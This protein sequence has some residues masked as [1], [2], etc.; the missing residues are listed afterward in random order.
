MAAQGDFAV[1]HGE[2][3]GE[4]PD[5][6]EALAGGNGN[7]LHLAALLADKMTVLLKICAKA[8]RLTLDVHLPGQTAGNQ[9]FQAIVDRGQRNRRHA[10]L[11]A[12]EHLRRRRMIALVQE[13]VVNFPALGRETMAVMADHLLI[14]G[15]FRRFH[16]PNLRRR[17]SGSRIILNW[18][19][20][21]V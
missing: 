21:A 9:R 12:K 1:R 8:G 13:N 6:L 19:M 7:I 3:L 20:R 11:G 5:A 18:I 14:T 16:C 10:L 17:Q 15:V 4:V 2:A